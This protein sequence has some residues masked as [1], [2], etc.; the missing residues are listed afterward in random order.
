MRKN[1][2]HDKPVNNRTAKL[3]SILAMAGFNLLH[4]SEDPVIRSL[5]KARNNFR[6]LGPDSSE[7]CSKLANLASLAHLRLLINRMPPDIVIDV[8]AN[9]GQFAKN[10]RHIGYDGPIV[11]FEPIPAL[12]TALKSQAASDNQWTIIEG[13]VGHTE[14]KR[15]FHQS[16]SSDFSSFLDPT[17]EGKEEFATMISEESTHL[18]QIRPLHEWWRT[19]T[20]PAPKRGLLKTDT[21]GYD[22]EVLK[23]SIAIL[24]GIHIVLSELSYIPLYKGAASASDVTEFLNT[25]QFSLSASFPISFSSGSCRM[26]E[27]D[28]FFVRDGI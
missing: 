24:P 28:G 20:L 19:H 16:F 3:N 10:L 2:T 15:T 13:A 22:I 4:V 25:L 23:G 12:A 11:S 27:A 8:G 7:W 5:D 9:C 18:I 17:D 26:I 14:E 1:N 21:Q 6:F